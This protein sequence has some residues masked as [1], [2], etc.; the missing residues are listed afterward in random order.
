MAEREKERETQSYVEFLKM[1]D[2]VCYIHRNVSLPFNYKGH[3][4]LIL[5]DNILMDMQK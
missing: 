2:T 5:H 4:K 3:S 1:N